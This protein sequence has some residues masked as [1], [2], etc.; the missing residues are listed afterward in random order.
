MSVPLIHI[1]AERIPPEVQVNRGEGVPANFWLKLRAEWGSEGGQPDRAVSLRMEAF[2]SHLAWLPAACRRYGVG[3]EWD[4]YSAHLVQSIRAER[5]TLAE[6]LR[7]PPVVDAE[8]A[9]GI[10]ADSN[11]VRKLMPFQLRDFANLLAIPHAANFSVPGAGKTSVAYS[12]YEA[13]RQSDRLARMLV[14]APISAFSTW[15]D[16]AV[17]C[18]AKAPQIQRYDGSGIKAETEV[19]IC[20]Y[21]RLTF[22]YEEIAAWVSA[23][24]CYVVLDEAHRMKRGW[25]GQWGSACLNLAFLAE[26]RG[27]LTGTPAPQSP[28]DL[29]AL[30]DFLWPNQANRIFPSAALI[31]DPHPESLAEV[32]KVIRPLF[33]R[34]TKRELGLTP[35]TYSA[36][37]VPLSE[38]HA[39]I[40]NALLRQ[41]A[42]S[43]ELQRRDRSTFARMGEIVMY[44]LEAATN[45]SLLVAGS[46]EHDPIVFRHPPLDIPEDSPLRELLLNYHH[47]ETP[48]KMVQLAQIVETNASND[49]K[50]LI[51]TNFVRNITTL[52]RMLARYSPA[53]VHGGIPSEVSQPGAPLVRE[54]EIDRF[55]NDEGCMVLIANPAAAGEGINLQE[56]C[57]DA[58]YLDRTFNAG[59]YLQSVDRIHRLGL[60]ADQETRITF[61]LS[62]GTIDEQV[63]SRVHDKAER[64][65]MMLDDPD[66][67]LM[68]LPDEEDYGLPLD[69]EGDMIALFAH[70]RGKEVE[71]AN[72]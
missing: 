50:T 58:V 23:K 5:D 67:V 13:E 7:N 6:I 49:R 11:L 22:S 2:L 43:Y 37:T 8:D 40:Y 18:F 47:Y 3:I 42:G 28:I 46:S 20:N 27:I 14:V 4:E 61:L 30:I 51:W 66:I 68:A 24:S 71:E 69:E 25:E 36:I 38:L 63:D 57:H 16:E 1:A 70:L 39:D 52:E 15:I 17:E 35:P 10:L 65:G 32:A 21:H 64:L 29:L 55:E 19:L 9:S 62:E 31:R 12:I 60:P 59:T 45:P 26:R 56:A 72:G 34:T 54:A 44:L 53:V 33:V 48:S 41:Y